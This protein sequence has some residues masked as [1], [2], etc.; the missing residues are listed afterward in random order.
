[1]KLHKESIDRFFDYDLHTETR[2]I[3]VGDSDE[4]VDSLMAERLI[5][6]LHLFLAADPEKE[7]RIILNSA[8]GYWTHGM[9]IYDAIMACTAHVTIEVYGNCMSM[10]S[11]IL[12][13][14]DERI[15]H[16]NT[17]FMIHD[18]YEGMS[19]VTPR[20]FEAW[21]K[22]S[23]L[24]RKRMY[25]IYSERSGKSVL[26]WEK[27]CSADFIMT[28]EEAVALGLADKVAGDEAND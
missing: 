21:G 2:T 1:M 13:A 23:K 26:Y 12:Q 19:E 16:P 14:A 7:I 15:I 18:G 27:K 4:G 17:T 10:G 20:T 6:A 8:G 3:Y 11:V 28:A 22:Q 9:A 25:E 5:K 24:T